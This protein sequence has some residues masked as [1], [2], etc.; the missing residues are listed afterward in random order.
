MENPETGKYL[1]N[2]MKD[3]CRIKGAGTLDF[4]CPKVLLFI[5]PQRILVI[6]LCGMLRINYMKF[7]FFNFFSDGG[8]SFSLVVYAKISPYNAFHVTSLI[9]VLIHTFGSIFSMFSTSE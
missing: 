1:Q 9:N 2:I 5:C 7:R 4:I 8:G 3:I 6:H